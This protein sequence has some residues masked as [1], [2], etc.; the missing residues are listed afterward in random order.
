MVQLT[1]N[2]EVTKTWSSRGGSAET[3]L[4]SVREDMGPIPGLAQWV[5]DLA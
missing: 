5:K 2:E 3:H 4:T 1:E